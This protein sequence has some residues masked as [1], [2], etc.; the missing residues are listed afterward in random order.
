MKLQKNLLPIF[1]LVIGAMLVGCS[2]KLD[3]N[4]AAKLISQEEQCPRE[5][6]EEI[7][8][9]EKVYVVYT[10]NIT[11]GPELF[12]ILKNLKQAGIIYFE[13]T[14]EYPKGFE[15]LSSYFNIRL[16]PEGEK[17][18]GGTKFHKKNKEYFRIKVCVKC[19]Y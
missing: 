19:L 10:R 14:G 9:G 5:V 4:L 8:L 6:S 2:K 15:G 12:Y 13:D 1:V 11:P 7:P 3:R 17:S 18:F 16:T